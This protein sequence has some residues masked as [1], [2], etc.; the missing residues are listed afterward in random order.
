MAQTRRQQRTVARRKPATRAKAKALGAAAQTQSSGK[1]A[2][3]AADKT[4]IA[5]LLAG[6]SAA[7]KRA[8]QAGRSM[9][10]TVEVAPDGKATTLAAPAAIDT[11]GDALGSALAAARARGKSRIAGILKSPDMLT[12]RDFGSLIGASHETVNVKRSRGEILGLQGAT[13]GVRYPSW[14]VTE[15]GMPLPGLPR[16]FQVLGQQPWAVYRFMTTAHSELGG[17]TGL[18]AMKAGQLDAAYAVAR[19][20]TSGAFS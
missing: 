8:R 18:E 4:L 10:F 19:N 15:A 16:L 11:D 2:Q 3:G 6:Y 17:K 20:Q 1:R 12:A 9:V 5:N 7:A 14:Q 13:R